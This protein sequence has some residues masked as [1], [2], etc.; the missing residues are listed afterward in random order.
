MS[1]HS[2]LYDEKRCKKV[3]NPVEKYVSNG[4]RDI[5][6]DLTFNYKSTSLD[7]RTDSEH[8]S[9][10]K[11]KK[12]QVYI[13]HFNVT[14]QINEQF[15]IVHHIRVLIFIETIDII[16]RNNSKYSDRCYNAT[17]MRRDT[18]RAHTIF[19]IGRHHVCRQVV[20]EKQLYEQYC[21]PTY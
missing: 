18:K 20:K 2:K 21:M 13:H 16:H 15:C 4:N 12:G 7:E 1:L 17:D 10:K 9:S 14:N 19:P 11:K 6:F 5:S 8:E 3:E